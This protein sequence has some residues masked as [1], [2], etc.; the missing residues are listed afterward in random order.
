MRDHVILWGACYLGFFGFLRAGE[1]TVNSAFQPSIH[2]TVD[3]LLDYEQSLFFCSPSNKTRDMQMATCG[4]DGAIWE[5]H[6]ERE[7]THKARENGLSWSSEFLAS[8]LK[9]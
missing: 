3:D 5:R 8:K 2:A 7:T 9:C 6:E 4:T 1:F